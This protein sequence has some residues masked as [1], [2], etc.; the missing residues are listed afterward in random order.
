MNARIEWGC[1]LLECELVQ[2]NQSPEVDLLLIDLGHR[3]FHG[4]ARIV[5]RQYA[6]SVAFVSVKRLGPD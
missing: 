1:T 2:L 3:G 4:E 6:S 5:E